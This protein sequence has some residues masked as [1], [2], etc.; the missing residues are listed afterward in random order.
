MITQ[1]GDSIRVAVT[2]TVGLSLM[3][4]TADSVTI[5]AHDGTET[6]VDLTDGTLTLPSY[7]APDLLAVKWFSGTD[8][9]AETSVEVVSRHY[10]TISDIEGYGDG[11]DGFDQLDDDVLFRARQAATDV[12]ELNSRRSF[13]HRIGRTKCYED[14]MLALDHNDVYQM[15]TDGYELVSDCQAVTTGSHEYPE[16]AEYLYGADYVPQ[17][18]SRAVLELTAYYLRP[19][20]RPIGATGESSDAGYIHFT[21]AGTDGATDIPE[22]NAAI[23]QFGRQV[24]AVW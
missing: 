8:E 17:Q 10:C 1:P 21:T 14:G 3:S 13:V 20:N 22:V 16:W 9:V 6:S 4:G 7:E 24:V 18:V 2:D 19:S 23:S 12:F 11:Q 15:L 5:T